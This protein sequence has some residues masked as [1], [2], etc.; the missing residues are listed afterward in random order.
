MPT[1]DPQGDALRASVIDRFRSVA[2][3]PDQERK[4]PIG[5]ESSKKLGYDPAEVDA[6]PSAVPESFCGGRLVVIKGVSSLLDQPK[7]LQVTK[8]LFTSPLNQSDHII[9]D[10]EEPTGQSIGTP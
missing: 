4:F 10:R 5:P 7:R 2:T 3:A 9:L 6:L 1:R 8:S